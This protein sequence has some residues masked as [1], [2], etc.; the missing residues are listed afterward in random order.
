MSNDDK[1]VHLKVVSKN[2]EPPKDDEALM[3]E[4]EAL[5]EAL[6][7]DGPFEYMLGVARRKDGKFM[8][9]GTTMDIR[10]YIFCVEFM[11]VTAVGLMESAFEDG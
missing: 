10:D 8:T 6:M 9:F 7:E 11:K 4:H 1:I 5:V 3:A 2:D